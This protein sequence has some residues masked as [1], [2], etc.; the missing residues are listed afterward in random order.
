MSEETFRL[1]ITGAVAISALCIVVVAVSALLLYKT[2]GRVEQQ[3]NRVAGKAEPL[4]DRVRVLTDEN[5]PKIS[6]LV[7]DAGEVTANAKEVTALAKDQAQRFAEVG[8]DI[9]DRAKVQVARVDAAV[10]ETV[11]QVQHVAEA[12]RGSVLK[13]V[14]EAGAV[15]AGLRAA[16]SSLGGNGRKANIGRIAQDEEMF[17]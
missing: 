17:I 5:G 13:P 3:V 16:V 4:I 9:A 1:V 2:V 14:K 6:K 12:V 7:S 8:R 11:E 15:I 10:D